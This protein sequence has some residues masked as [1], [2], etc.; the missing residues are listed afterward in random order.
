[1]VVNY[2]FDP[3]QSALILAV[4]KS[5]RCWIFMIFCAVG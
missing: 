3:F 1:M 4:V 2:P 5:F